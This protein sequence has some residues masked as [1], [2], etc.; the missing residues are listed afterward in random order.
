MLTEGAMVLSEVV[1]VVA[2][3]PLLVLIL[4]CLAVGAVA[5]TAVSAAANF[6]GKRLCS[7]PRSS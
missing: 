5:I 6:A 3:V 4:G 1:L 2:F 7:Q